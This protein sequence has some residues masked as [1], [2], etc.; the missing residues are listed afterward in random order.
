MERLHVLLV[1]NDDDTRDLY[2]FMLASAGVQVMA[3]TNGL[4][5]LLSLQEDRPDLI[6]TDVAM[7]VVSGVELIKIVKSRADYADLPVIAMTAHGEKIRR[8]ALSAGAN[9][10][11]DKPIRYDELRNAIDSALTLQEG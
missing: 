3:V 8:L 11:M 9:K 10:A 6:I 4:E 5:A 2:S 7:P 1:E